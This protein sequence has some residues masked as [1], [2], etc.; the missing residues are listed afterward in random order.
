MLK[1]AC[2]VKVYRIGNMPAPKTLSVK[3]SAA[4]SLL[5]MLT[6]VVDKSEDLTAYLLAD[7]CTYDSSRQQPHLCRPFPPNCKAL[8]DRKHI[9]DRQWHDQK[10]RDINLDLLCHQLQNFIIR[11]R[12]LE[13]NLLQVWQEIAG[14]D[15]CRLHMPPQPANTTWRLFWLRS[16]P[17]PS[18]SGKAQRGSS[19][20]S[21]RCPL[22]DTSQKCH[23]RSQGDAC[24]R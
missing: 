13:I 20:S 6:R 12:L 14:D 4:T 15:H 7:G 17:S 2:F 16:Y 18:A 22:Q 24:R 3:Q 23:P 8:H 11:G 21:P 10:I 5:A 19:D 9:Q 1:S